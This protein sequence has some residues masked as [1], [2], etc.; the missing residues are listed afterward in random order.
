LIRSR[1]YPLVHSAPFCSLMCVALARRSFTHTQLRSQVS[2]LLLLF[3]R[4]HQRG[5]GDQHLLLHEQGPQLHLEHSVRP[6]RERLRSDAGAA[7]GATRAAGVQTDAVARGGPPHRLREEAALPLY[8]LLCVLH[9]NAHA[10]GIQRGLAGQHAELPLHV[11]GGAGDTARLER[12][13]GERRNCTVK[14]ICC[15]ISDQALSSNQ[16]P[17]KD[18]RRS[19]KAGSELRSKENIARDQGIDSLLL[20]LRHAT[21]IYSRAIYSSAARAA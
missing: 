20:S 7:T 17:K 1:R 12:R 11:E 6:A 3:G 5:I 18:L 16:A 14:K 21:S 10:A 9:G 8:L 19:T 15:W 2:E 4:E 13:G